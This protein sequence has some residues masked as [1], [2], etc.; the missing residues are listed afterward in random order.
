MPDRIVRTFGYWAGIR[1]FEQ[2]KRLMEEKTR[3]A[4]SRNRELAKGG[5]FTVRRGDFAKGIIDTEH[6]PSMLKGGIVAKDYLG[7]SATS[8]RTPFDM[9]VELIKEDGIMLTAKGYTYT[10]VEKRNL[11]KII[12]VIKND[13]SYVQTREGKN[14]NEENINIVKS[15]RTQKEFFDNNGEGGTNAYG[16]RTGIGSTNISYI[17]ADRYVDKLGLEIAMNGFYIPIVDEKGKILFTPEMYDDIRSRMQGLS[18]YGLNEFSLDE[19]AKNEGVEQIIGLIE[20][21]KKDASFKRE[22]ILQTLR[23]AI[24][25]EGITMFPER[26]DTLMPN[27]AEVVDTGSTGRGTNEPGDGDFDF[28]MR[29]DNR[30]KQNPGRT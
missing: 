27:I 14:E 16:I 12:L 8:D 23:T 2:A 15:D 25:S 21:S 11:G 3:Q 13:G 6:F 4:D 9:D 7:Q 22:K 30:L 19:S 17:I 18:Y 1:D 20:Q 5:D 28:M 24:E 26:V 29:L 10:D